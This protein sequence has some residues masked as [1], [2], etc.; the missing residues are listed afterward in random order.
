MAK[1]ALTNSK[2]VFKNN[3]RLSNQRK[4]SKLHSF[5]FLVG[6]VREDVLTS[7]PLYCYRSKSL[8]RVVDGRCSRFTHLKWNV[9]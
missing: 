6:I 5:K 3:Y 4:N 2:N 8:V 7:C 9:N 1:V